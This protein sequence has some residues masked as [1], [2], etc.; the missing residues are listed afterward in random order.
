VYDS[1]SL[2]LFIAHKLQK[3][4]IIG[5]TVLGLGCRIKEMKEETCK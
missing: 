1:E 3:V 2:E 4:E 5:G